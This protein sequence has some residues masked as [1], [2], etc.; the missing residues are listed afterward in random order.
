MSMR[1]LQY[2]PR[3]FRWLVYALAAAFIGV[4]FWAGFADTYLGSVSP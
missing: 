2:A 4:T 3:W 1:D